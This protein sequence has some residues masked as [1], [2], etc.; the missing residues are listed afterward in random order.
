MSSSDN[1]SNAEYEAIQETEDGD[2]EEVVST[3]FSRFSRFWDL[4]SPRPELVMAASK[5]TE[6][7]EKKK[8]P[9][10]DWDNHI[11]LLDSAGVAS[12]ID[13]VGGF[14]THRSYQSLLDDPNQLTF[15]SHA[16]KAEDT[17]RASHPSEYSSIYYTPEDQDADFMT[18]DWA[19]YAE[20]DRERKRKIDKLNQELPEEQQ[21]LAKAWDGLQTWIALLLI[22]FFTG[23]IAAVVGI[24]VDLFTDLRFGFCQ[25]RGFWI[26]REMCCKEAR[27]GAACENWRD[28][29]AMLGDLSNEQRRWAEFGSYSLVSVLMASFAAW[30]CVTFAP[31][32]AGSGISEVKVVLGGFVIKRLLGGWTLICKSMGLMLAVGAG[33]MVGKEGP[34]VHLGC[35]M[36]NLISRLFAKYRGNE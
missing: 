19:Y 26:S 21:L 17:G 22:G 4:V 33:M 14:Y 8:S 31:Y 7:K 15:R 36:A 9:N 18:V 25:G 11:S 29:H 30:L 12:E 2:N 35:C 1:P 32:A 16:S 27:V 3:P 20:K 34:C 24:G 28:W 23:A 5:D 10:V 13:A 6:E